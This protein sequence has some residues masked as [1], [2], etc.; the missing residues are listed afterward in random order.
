MEL[1]TE[2]TYSDLST[3]DII[4]DRKTQTGY[5]WVK[6]KDVLNDRLEWLNK[7]PKF[8][9]NKFG[10]T[11]RTFN[12]LS[13][14]FLDYNIESIKTSRLSSDFSI[15]EK[16]AEVVWQKAL[17]GTAYDFGRAITVDSLGNVYAIG[18]QNSSTAGLND[19]GVLKLDTNG[20]LM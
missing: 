18:Y 4:V 6:P 14:N 19:Y 9:F 3:G 10:E 7:L 16:I 2:N 5:I 20:N 8:T 15:I 13:D 11:L 17:G 1:S 12:N